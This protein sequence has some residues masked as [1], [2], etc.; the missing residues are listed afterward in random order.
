M[1]PFGLI[2]VWLTLGCHEVEMHV[3]LQ[4]ARVAWKAKRV[5]EAASLGREV[6]ILVFVVPEH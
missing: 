6:G 1:S 3:N 2:R 4:V 5:V